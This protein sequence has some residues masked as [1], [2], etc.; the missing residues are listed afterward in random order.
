MFNLT[1]TELALLSRAAKRA[2]GGVD[3]PRSLTR[4]T[5]TA[6]TNLLARRLLRSCPAQP[7]SPPWKTDA[8]GRPLAL[9]ITKAGRRVVAKRLAEPERSDLP[10]VR[11]GAVATRATPPARKQKKQAT[12]RPT[13]RGSNKG[14][15]TRR[16]A[17]PKPEP[18]PVR[19][20]RPGSKLARVIDL[21]RRSGGASVADIAAATGWQPHTVRGV[22]SGAVRTKLHLPVTTEAM[23]GRRTYRI[24]A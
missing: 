9:R 15:T 1:D 4:A 10:M 18:A 12:T 5:E 14:E 8:R 17:K 19:S 20:P 3:V 11:V 13:D 22:I 7:G 21:L 24:E 2:K 6:I 16:K 23:D